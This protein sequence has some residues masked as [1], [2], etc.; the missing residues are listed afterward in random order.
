GINSYSNLLWV[1]RTIDRHPTKTWSPA[2]LVR[3]GLSL[4]RVSRPAGKFFYSN[5]NTL[6]LGLII[7][8]L[9]RHDLAHVFERRIFRPLH[10][11]HTLFPV[12]T[13]NAITGPHP[14][15]YL[16]GSN[17]STLRDPALPPR[18][19]RLAIQ[20]KLLPNDVTAENPSW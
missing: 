4:P 10:M 14:Q 18:K 19:R 13:S 8:K 15:G 5:T 20:G 17:V 12:L 3:V 11:R 9:T 16:F 2:H 7:Q 1:N 6:M